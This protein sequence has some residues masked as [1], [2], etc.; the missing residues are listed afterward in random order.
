MDV[1]EI[2]QEKRLK[3]FQDKVNKMLEANIN[4]HFSNADFR[5]YMDPRSADSMLQDLAHHFIHRAVV[6]GH[7]KFKAD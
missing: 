1:T 4:E 5:R 7:S 2:L 3:E 6:V